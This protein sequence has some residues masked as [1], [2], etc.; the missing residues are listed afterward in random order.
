MSSGE[1]AYP[2]LEIE[3]SPLDDDELLDDLDVIMGNVY[4][5]GLDDSLPPMT[6]SPQQSPLHEA[7]SCS[8]MD[9]LDQLADL[10]SDG[11][12]DGVEEVDLLEEIGWERPCDL[13]P[14]NQSG[15]DVMIPPK[16]P[17]AVI[18]YWKPDHE[19]HPYAYETDFLRAQPTWRAFSEDRGKQLSVFELL[20][21]LM[22]KDPEYASTRMVALQ[23]WEAW[24]ASD[25]AQSH[26]LMRGPV[27][28]LFEQ[29]SFTLP[30]GSYFT[31]I[32]S[33]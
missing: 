28:C 9:E 27:D 6:P 33:E 16:S 25:A 4:S 11:S 13:S 21:M 18:L 10:L 30:P 17:V 31:S 15:D 22:V 7:L 20:G 2:P 24:I 23:H 29:S 32:Y 8:Q 3:D 26:N 12:S 19:V 14:L 1:D 5:P